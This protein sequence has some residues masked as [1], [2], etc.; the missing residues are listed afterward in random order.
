MAVI[1]KKA[2]KKAAHERLTLSQLCDR[3]TSMAVPFEDVAEFLENSTYELCVDGKCKSAIQQLSRV[4]SFFET[5]EN[6]NEENCRDLADTYILIG[7]VN[8]YVG[9]FKESIEWF[10]KAAVVFDRYAMPF[11]NLATSYLELGDTKNAVKSLEQEIALEPG[12]YFSCLRLADLYEQQGEYKKEEECLE[13]LLARNPDNIQALHKLITHYEN[14]QPGVDIKLL[15]RRLVV[16]DKNFNEIEMVIRTYH[17]C[18]EG[19]YDKA[20]RFLDDESEK[21]P[22]MTMLYL[23]KAYVLGQIHEFS[24]KRRQLSEFKQHCQGKAEYMKNRLDEFEHIFGKKA[25]SRLGKILVVTNA[26]V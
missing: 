23:L 24:K 5:M 20:L 13:N 8:Q 25:M 14:Q 3:V 4:T 15:R 12:N 22:A 10:K 18:T 17:L 7:E 16:I 19:L 6:K 11:H 26:N 2:K 1:A 9:A 21:N